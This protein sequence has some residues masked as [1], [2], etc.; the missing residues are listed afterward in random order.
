MI[1]LW[2]DSL[3]ESNSVVHRGAFAIVVNPP[4]R[5]V[6]KRTSVHCTGWVGSEIGHFC[7][8][9]V[10]REWFGGLENPPK[11]AYRIVASSNARY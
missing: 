3:Q 10:H 4:E 7:L 11:H 9:T 2:H 8:P 5:K 1:T 6:A